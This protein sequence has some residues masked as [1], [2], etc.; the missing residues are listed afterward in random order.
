M[1]IWNECSS[2][3]D[4][5]TRYI[6]TQPK[7]WEPIIELEYEILELLCY[8]HKNPY[9]LHPNGKYAF[10]DEEWYC[11]LEEAIKHFPII[12]SVKR[13]SD[14]EV[15]SIGDKVKETITGTCKGWDI[16]EFTYKD[17]RCFSA[18]VNINNIEKYKGPLL[19]TEDGYEIYDEK[20]LLWDTS[21][22]NWNFLEK[23][24]AKYFPIFNSTHRKCWY[25]K[26]NAQN[27]IFMNKP[28]LSLNDLL[29]V[30][31]EDEDSKK[32]YK[33]SLLFKKFENLAKSKR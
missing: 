31:G 16:S 8:N 1:K 21:D 26:E 12:K 4:I 15:F 18:G 28:S 11:S 24:E 9:V 7:Y 27:Y 20:Q 29:S 3:G 19:I 32:F 13:L 22:N 10:K 23:T 30:W 17:T 25:K 6:S 5:F 33:S 2:D 14:G